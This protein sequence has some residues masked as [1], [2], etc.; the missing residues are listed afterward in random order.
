MFDF[1][2]FLTNFNEVCYRMFDARSVIL[3]FTVIRIVTVWQMLIYSGYARLRRW[4]LITRLLLYRPWLDSRPDRMGFTFYVMTLAQVF[5]WT[6]WFSYIS[7]IPTLFKVH[8]FIADT[9]ELYFKTASWNKAI[10][11]LMLIYMKLKLNCLV[12]VKRTR[13]I[14]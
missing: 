14:R 4:L 12:Y 7:T 3:N 13:Y 10:Y 1:I 6:V 5:H 8:L 2:N 11:A 9:M